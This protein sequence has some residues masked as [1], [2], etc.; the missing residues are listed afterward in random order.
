M[1]ISDFKRGTTFININR[2][3]FKEEGYF[4]D[5]CNFLEL[6]KDCISIEIEVDAGNACF[7]PGY[8]GKRKE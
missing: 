7:S 6:P 8:K 1:T 4:E 2:S 5:L 3:W